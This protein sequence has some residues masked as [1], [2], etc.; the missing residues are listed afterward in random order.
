M[1]DLSDQN[2]L[3]MLEEVEIFHVDHIKAFVDRYS[4]IKFP[5]QAPQPS[6]SSEGPSNAEG[7]SIFE[8]KTVGQM[9]MELEQSNPG[10]Y[11]AVAFLTDECI[12]LIYEKTVDSVRNGR[13]LSSDWADYLTSEQYNKGLLSRRKELN[14]II[15]AS[16][17]KRRQL[18]ENS[19]K[20]KI[21]RSYEQMAATNQV[22]DLEASS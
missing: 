17:A 2:F 10:L 6:R 15:E 1:K 12:Q 9:K 21:K 20:E 18:Q 11:E 19:S 22:V 3:K 13:P 14:A 8:M 7:R 5:P 4:G 16:N